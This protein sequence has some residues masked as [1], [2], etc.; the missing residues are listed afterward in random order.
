MEAMDPRRV[1]ERAAAALANRA[2]ST[3]VAPRANLAA[4][5]PLNVSP[6]AVVSRTFT[7]YPGIGTPPLSS[8]TQQPAA[9][10][11]TITAR[12]PRARKAL[13]AAAA[14]SKF[15]GGLGQRSRIEDGRH[16]F[17]ESGIEC[18]AHCLKGCFQLAKE[19]I[20]GIDLLGYL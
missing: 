4:S 12:A 16:S 18:C 9:P 5:A 10:I 2:A 8:A 13:A 7:T 20:I 15:A 3:S 11:F 14:S 1:T 19:D 6:A 17:F